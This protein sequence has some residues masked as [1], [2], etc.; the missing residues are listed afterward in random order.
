MPQVDRGL[1]STEADARGASWKQV[2]SRC[3]PM[4]R[5]PANRGTEGPHDEFG[6]ML[7]LILGGL[8]QAATQR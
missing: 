2:P 6:F 8:E 7:D 5:S 1:R 3:C 4:V